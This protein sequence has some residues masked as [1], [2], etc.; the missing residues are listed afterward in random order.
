MVKVTKGEQSK[1]N[2][3]ECAANLFIQKGYNATGINDILQCTGLPKGSFYFH[4]KSKKDLAISVSDYF[5]RKIIE[6]A[7]VSAK[8]KEWEA[9]IKSLSDTMIAGAEIN[10]HFGCPFAV[11]GLEIAFSEP[12]LAEY[13]TRSMDRL[14]GIFADVLRFS[15]VKEDKIP[16][17][18]NRAFAAY[19]GYLV[20][21]RLSK[22]I[23]TLRRMADDLISIYKDY[24][25]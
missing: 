7:L 6:M 12:D 24:K 1:N 13:Y 20:Y 17:L 21:Y 11:L 3:I 14:N 4:F 8:D 18:A 19:E 23:D 25:G 9:F 10:K 2:L 5:E 16:T 22:D 15:K